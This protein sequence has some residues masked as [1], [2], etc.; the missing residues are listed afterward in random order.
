MH[1]GEH[2][3][4]N[5]STLYHIQYDNILHINMYNIETATV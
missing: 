2:L 1:F 4:L 3:H 5:Q